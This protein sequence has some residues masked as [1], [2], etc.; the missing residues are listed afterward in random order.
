M[1]PQD[2]TE[3]PGTT[4]Q[5]RASEATAIE[6]ARRLLTDFLRCPSCATVL[7]GS[8]CPAC[9]VDLS[10]PQ[11][12]RVGELSARAGELLTEREA[13]LRVLRARADVR[14]ASPSAAPV[15]QFTAAQQ[16]AQ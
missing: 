10:G 7:G 5:A 12:R 13:I 1:G 2:A 16:P 8:R 6:V 11:A 15:P 14:T 9:G 4:E 3:A